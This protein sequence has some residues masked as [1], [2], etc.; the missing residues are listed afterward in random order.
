MIE[1]IQAKE[2]FRFYTRLHLSEMTGLK[3]ATLS[4]L[5]EII[6]QVPDACIYHHTHKFLQQHQYISPEPPNDFAYW[7]TEILGEA[8][9]GEQLASIDIMQFSEISALRS[10]IAEIIENYLAAN[11]I[12][13]MRFAKEGEEFHFMKT[14]SFIIPTAYEVHNLAEFSEALK[15]ITIDSIYFHIFEARLRLGKQTNDF[16]FWLETSLG[17]KALGD[18]IA[19]LD[20]YTR[21][22]EDLRETIIETVNKRINL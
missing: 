1:L 12:S 7:I 21:T 15:K 11:K 5:L 20:P 6:K 14:I 3:A 13:Y 2:P 4:Q 8:D 19:S 9:L 16:S 22:L 17:D 18:Q 10:K